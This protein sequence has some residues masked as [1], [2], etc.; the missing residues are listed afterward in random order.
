MKQWQRTL[1]NMAIL[2]A[3]HLLLQYTLIVIFARCDIVSKL[4]AAGSHVPISTL[5]GALFFILTRIMTGFILPGLILAGLGRVAF[6][7]YKER[8]D[9]ER[10]QL[11]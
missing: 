5:I 9:A 4:F 1:K 10:E 8:T 3:A 11:H 2:T 7:A 6:E